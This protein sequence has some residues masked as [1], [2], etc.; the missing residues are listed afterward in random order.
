M[1][2]SGTGELDPSYSTSPRNKDDPA[3][4]ATADTRPV[5]YGLSIAGSEVAKLV[6]AGLLA[7]LDQSTVLA[8]V[9]MV[10][11]LDRKMLRRLS[12]GGAL[13]CSL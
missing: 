11:E 4:I 3:G 12:H 8:G 9:K 10:A 13:K 2:D 6:L 5:I 1:L 7:D